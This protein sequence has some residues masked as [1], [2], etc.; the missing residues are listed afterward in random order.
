MKKLFMLVL[1]FLFAGCA[2]VI[3][4]EGSTLHVYEKSIKTG[5]ERFWETISI[6]N[7]RFFN[8]NMTSLNSKVFCLLKNEYYISR[9]LVY[10]WNNIFFNINS[11]YL[12]S[13]IV[14][15]KILSVLCLTCTRRMIIR[16]QNFTFVFQN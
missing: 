6:Y 11:L 15:P 9:P 4:K 2:S 10:I 3:N 1:V 5:I 12:L 8:C 7:I 14:V 16:R 13:Y